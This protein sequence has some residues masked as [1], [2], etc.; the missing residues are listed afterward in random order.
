MRAL[1]IR[2]PWVELILRGDKQV[3]YRTWKTNH[4]GD[5]LIHASATHNKDVRANIEEQGLEAAQLV[6]GAVVGVVE[7]TRYSVVQP[8]RS[9]LDRVRGLFSG[10]LE[11]PEETVYEWHLANPR[12]FETPI[13]YKGAAGIFLVPDEALGDRSL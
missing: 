13:P 6:F 12:R 1:S 2:Q 7:V 11:E 4:L 10:R 5:L 9:L 8:Q 3:E